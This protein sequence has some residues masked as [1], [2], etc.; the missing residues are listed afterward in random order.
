MKELNTKCL[1]IGSGPAGYTAAIY[2][3]RANMQPLLYEG[4]QPGGQLTITSIVENFPGYP[5]GRSGAEIMEDMRNQALRFGTDI[6]RGEIISVD[7]SKRPFVC[8]SDETLKIIA[9][10]V[11]IASGASARWLGL[12]SESIF[13]GH[14]V[15]TCATCD[16]FFY[17]NKTTV[18]IGGGDTAAE[19]ALYLSKLCSKV[20][21]VH[22][23]DQ[24][25]ASKIMQTRLFNAPNIEIIWEHIP[26]EILGTVQGFAKNVTGLKIKH[27]QSGQEQILSVDGVFVAIG[28]HPNTDLFKGQITLDDDNYIITEPGTSK[29]NVPGIFAAGDVQDRHY[30]QAITAAASGCRAAIDAE[31]FL[32]M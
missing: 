26:L 18:I 32:S 31:R 30:K 14:G 17:K 25:R 29:T 8:L 2:S 5:E 3:A 6:R 7:F 12:P 13:Y 4:I 15:S 20:Y 23:R 19:D 22:R 1:I 11:I 28:H 9:E 27:T 16:G 10:T 21:L 24:L